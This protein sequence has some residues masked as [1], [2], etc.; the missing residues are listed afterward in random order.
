VFTRATLANTLL[1]GSTWSRAT[2][3]PDEHL[4]GVV[5]ATSTNVG[6]GRFRVGDLTTAATL[7]LR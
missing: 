4:K 5:E 6:N 2:V 3:W 7:D 1:T